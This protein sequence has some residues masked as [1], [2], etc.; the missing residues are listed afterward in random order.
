MIKKNESRFKENDLIDLKSSSLEEPQLINMG[1]TN[2]QHGKLMYWWRYAL[3]TQVQETFKNSD[4]LL[5][6]FPK[7]QS[8]SRNYKLLMKMKK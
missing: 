4:V 7:L 5:L 1:F 8:I 3:K 6:D 2:A